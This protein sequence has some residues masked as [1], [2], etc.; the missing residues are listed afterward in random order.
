MQVH[1]TQLETIEQS[2]ESLEKVRI[3]QHFELSELDKKVNQFHQVVKPLETTLQAHQQQLSEVDQ[4]LNNLEQTQLNQHMKLSSLG[5]QLD[6]VENNLTHHQKQLHTLDK[7][8]YDGFQV[9]QTHLEQVNK[10]MAEMDRTTKDQAVKLK[11]QLKGII[12]R[13]QVLE[14]RL[15]DPQQRA[16][17][18]ASILPDAI[19]QA[20]DQITSE[21][22]N[23]VNHSVTGQL[24][25]LQSGQETES[26][27]KSDV[28]T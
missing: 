9:Q 15:N 3:S 16:A 21:L 4:Y 6:I 8:F 20:A 7:Q 28:Q 24:D 5:K 26:E 23:Q 10:H 1:Q 25:H 22:T 14:T 12:S 19:K 13:Y 17:D 18:I 11:K 2:I 27:I